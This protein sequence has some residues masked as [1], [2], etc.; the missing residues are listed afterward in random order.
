MQDFH[1]HLRDVLGAAVEAAQSQP[2]G[3]ERSFWA[4]RP[5]DNFPPQTIQS[6]DEYD[7]S[8]R[9]SIACTQ[10]EL[11]A[12]AQR[13][14]VE[15]WCRFLP[16]LQGV[17]YVWF[18]SKVTQ[19][20]FEAVCRVRGLEGLYVKWSSIDTIA[21]IG[22]AGDLKYLHVGSS[23]GITDLSPLS[24]MDR[25]VWLELDNLKTV[26]DL[27]PLQ[28]LGQ[29]EGLGFTGPEGGRH[30]VQS[31]APL[32]TLLRLRWLH[33]G[34]IRAADDSLRPLAALKDLRWL[35][36]A[37]FFPWQEFAWL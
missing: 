23:P 18:Q 16:E 37:K 24:T 32:A 10:T 8:D 15:R 9:L 12:H 4:H 35:G 28:G 26:A 1:A 33:L 20:M 2:A 34:A 25:L 19:E 6:P 30:G 14:L 36:V 31:F 7:G 17:R 11:P 22:E 13:E 29:L 3:P 5:K 21:S 27:T